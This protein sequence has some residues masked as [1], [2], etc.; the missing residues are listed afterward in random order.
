MPAAPRAFAKRRRFFS[1]L[2]RASQSEKPR[3]KTAGLFRELAQAGSELAPPARVLNPCAS[4][5]CLLR[6]AD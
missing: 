1:T 5:F 3:F 2:A 4:H 6:A